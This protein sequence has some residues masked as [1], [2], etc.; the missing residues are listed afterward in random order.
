MNH[1]RILCFV[2]ILLTLSWPILGNAQEKPGK[3]EFSCAGWERVSEEIFY[4]KE[5]KKDQPVFQKVDI[6]EMVRSLS[7][8]VECDGNIAFYRKSGNAGSTE[9]SYKQV[10]LAKIPLRK[11]RFTLLF[12]PNKDGTY[13]IRTILDDRTDSPFG[14]YQFYNLSKLTISGVLAGQEFKLAPGTE[15]LL[16]LNL[17]P[18]TALPYATYIDT[19]GKRTW[20]QRN[21]MYFNPEKHLKYFLYAEED[22]NKRLTVKSKGLVEF[23]LPEK[24]ETGSTETPSLSTNVE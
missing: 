13:L 16:Q 22:Q 18:K 3:I 12:F 15:R 17:A 7:Y 21:T 2:G 14:A 9:P 6:G 10:A 4:V 24:T 20:L 1:S 19:D 8:Q 11:K 5:K 23:K